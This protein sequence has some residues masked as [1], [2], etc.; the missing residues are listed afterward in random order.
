MDIIKF[1]QKHVAFKDLKLFFTNF[2]GMVGSPINLWLY[3]SMNLNL[4]D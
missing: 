4:L 3:K 1:L 2:N